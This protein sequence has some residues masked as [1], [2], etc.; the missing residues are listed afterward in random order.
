VTSFSSKR[1]RWTERVARDQGLTHLAFRVA[2]LLGCHMNKVTGDAWPSQKLLARE[3]GVTVRAVQVS[4]DALVAAGYLLVDVA[5]GRSH[6]NRY[7]PVLDDPNTN[8]GSPIDGGKDEHEFAINAAKTR[9]AVQEKTNGCS[10]KGEPPFVQN[11]LQ[12]TFSNEPG[13]EKRARSDEGER[14][15]LPP[16]FKLTPPMIAYAN[17][18]GFDHTR[19]NAMFVAFQNHHAAKGTRYS[20]W[21]AGWKV[22]VDKEPQFK[23][24][25]PPSTGSFL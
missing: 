23:R 21:N 19:A 5:K 1:A 14:T 16:D 4:L 3:L 10:K 24:S 25:E 8:V 11:L 18:N 12:G 6:T 9:T 15:T 2:Y 20:D 13:R 17:A 7:C 22:W